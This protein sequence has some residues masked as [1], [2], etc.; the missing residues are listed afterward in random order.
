MRVTCAGGGPAGLWCA[1]L[2]ALHGHEVT[3]VERLPADVSTGWGFGYWDDL[4]HG[5]E[6]FDPATA[7]AVRAAS[8][9][10]AGQL[11]RIDDHPPVHLGG[12]GYGMAR[13]RLLSILAARAREL[14]VEMRFGTEV[15][16]VGDLPAAD[17]VV[18]ADGGRS[19]VRGSAAGAFGTTERPGSTMH[20]WLGT[21][22]AFRSFTFAFRRTRAGW[23][24]FH[25]YAHG[26]DAG[27][28]IIECSTS[29]W[30]GLGL[31]AADTERGLRILTEVFADHLEGGELLAHRPGQPTSRWA[32][33][34]TVSNARWV[35]GNVVLVGDAARTTHF[36]IGSGTRSAVH[37]AIALVPVLEAS[38]RDVPAGLLRYEADRRR[39]AAGI[40]RDA[41]RSHAWFEDV[42]RQLQRSPVD[43]GYCLRTRRAGPPGAALDDG[44]WSV[45]YAL[46]RVTQ[47]AIGRTLRTA[48]GTARR[49]WA[50]SDV[51]A[52]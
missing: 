6:A 52:H 23:I 9:D 22:V 47:F 10:W 24:W 25:G 7:R 43:V 30:A 14:G 44:R 3:L 27:T 32:R 20:L 36:S 50:S 11:L 13:H 38:A 8:V 40:I 4:V 19:A 16:G 18:A 51:V 5:L 49:R 37:D 2:A 29:T 41:A 26:P 15:R 46:H 48:V 28:V 34:A 42:D 35:H 12:Y 21:T 31:D 45:G 39:S 1:V 33:F 17:L